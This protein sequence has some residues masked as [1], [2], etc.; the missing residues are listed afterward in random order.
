MTTPP[1]KP[2]QHVFSLVQSLS[3]VHL[4]VTPLNYSMPGLP[5]Y[6]QLLEFTQTHVHCVGDAIQ[7]S[8]P[9]PSPSPPAL[10]L[11]QHQ[12]LFQ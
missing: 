2:H 4:S 3:R 8:H 7:P 12:G 10:N 5:D 9:L 1:R 6:H 11:C